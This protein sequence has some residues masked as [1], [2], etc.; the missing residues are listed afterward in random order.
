MN[1]IIN[2]YFSSSNTVLKK[3]ENSIL[4]DINKI[5]AYDYSVFKN[6]GHFQSSLDGINITASN[7]ELILGTRYVYPCEQ[8]D[9]WLPYHPNMPDRFQQ[10]PPDEVFEL[11][12]NI[13]NCVTKY[14]TITTDIRTQEDPLDIFKILIGDE[15]M[16]ISNKWYDK[17]DFQ[18]MAFQQS[19]VDTPEPF[20]LQFVYTVLS[21]LK[22]L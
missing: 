1:F 7:N 13:I 14:V 4:E 12:I 18:E 20:D 2:K 22:V 16:L 21:K 5:D 17:I 15:R 19:T 10:T 6:I 9:V 8:Q 11:R 3:L